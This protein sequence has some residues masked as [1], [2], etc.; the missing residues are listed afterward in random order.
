LRTASPQPEDAASAAPPPRGDV[1]ISVLFCCDPGYYQHLAVALVS[2]LRSN[3]RNF[4]DIHLISSQRDTASE[5]KLAASLSAYGNFRFQTYYWNHKTPLYTSYHITS[6][7]YTRLFASAILDKSIRKILYLDSDLV[8]IDDLAPV[9]ETDIQDYVLAAAPDPFGAGRREALGMPA[10]RTYVNSGVL[11]LN[12]DRWRADD[13]PARLAEYARREGANLLFHDQDAINA[14]LHP[15]T[16]ILDYRW[17]LQ[18]RMLRRSQTGS[19]PDRTAI[20]KAASSPAI[21]HYTS[22]RKPW[23]FVMATP[24]TR[25]YREHL[26]LTEWREAAPLGKSW[27]SLPEYIFNHALYHL[28]T[29]Y[30]WDRVL[31]STT[32]GRIIDRSTRLLTTRL[33]PWRRRRRRPCQTVK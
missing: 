29:D 18:A 17:N 13:L 26:R 28:G 15:W 10:G 1:A 12:L 19:L 5:A 8:V 27:A 22:A 31:R 6:D 20:R 3:S 9:W 25:L 11:L 14:V 2:L 7:A 30:T 4:L 23:V 33:G 24:A 32:I 21:V 16:R